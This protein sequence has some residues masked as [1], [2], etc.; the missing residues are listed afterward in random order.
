MRSN[1]V[2]LM[3]REVLTLLLCMTAEYHCRNKSLKQKCDE[4]RDFIT[5]HADEI[6]LT[7]FERVIVNCRANSLYMISDK[8]PKRM[9]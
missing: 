3:R 1:S 6:E 4:M 7:P 8:E 9:E 2:M 5:S